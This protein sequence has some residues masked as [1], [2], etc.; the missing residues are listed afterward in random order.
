MSYVIIPSGGKDPADGIRTSAPAAVT[1]YYDEWD[2]R[3][4]P[5]NYNCGWSGIVDLTD[6]TA[7]E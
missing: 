6:M 2:W 4:Y 5:C 1:G 3:S 7:L